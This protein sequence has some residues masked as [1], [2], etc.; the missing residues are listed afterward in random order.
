MDMAVEETVDYKLYW[1]GFVDESL[2]LP[3]RGWFLSTPSVYSLIAVG[4]A[5]MFSLLQGARSAFL[6]YVISFVLIFFGTRARNGIEF[7]KRHFG[8]LCLVIICMMA[9]AKSGY[10]YAASNG[11]LGESEEKKYEEQTKAGDSPLQMIISGRVVFFVG[12]YAA[13]EHPIVGRGS[14]AMDYDGIYIDFLRKYGV[15][16]DYERAIEVQRRHTF[17]GKIPSH[18]HIVTYWLWHG[19]FGLIFWSYILWLVI[20]TVMRYL[21]VVRELFGY[22]ALAIPTFLWDILFS[23]AGNRVSEAVLFVLCILVRKMAK[24]NKWIAT[25]IEWRQVG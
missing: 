24:G 17:I 25:S 21:D 3:V 8:L 6:S 10:K 5:A 4:G 7:V 13:L 11:L 15:Q 9:M 12:A 19:I 22:F 18:S 20:V 14:W 2:L 23:P 16:E 1:I